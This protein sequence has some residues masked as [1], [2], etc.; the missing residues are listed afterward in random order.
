MSA[1]SKRNRILSRIAI[2]LVITFFVAVLA[3]SLVAARTE[4][5]ISQLLY[6]ESNLPTPP[7]VEVAG[8][9]YVRAAFDHELPSV[10][11]T[12]QDIDVPGWGLMSVKSSAQYVTVTSE[13]VFTGTIEDA[14]ARKVFTRLQLD[15]V[16]IG[17]RME[18]DDLLIQNL[19][20]ISPRGGWETEAVFE[21]TPKGFREP[22]TVEMKLRVV[23]GQVI[24]SPQKIIKAPTS[25]DSTGN[26]VEGEELS[27]STRQEIMDAFRL[28][29]G[30]KSLPLKDK[31]IR[32]YVAGGGVFIESEQFYTSV[33]IQDL[34]PNTRP[35]SEDEEPGL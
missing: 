31:P 27:E 16:S 14:P 22:A 34:M 30:A 1:S 8:F 11:V 33:S 12:A 32:V 24:I 25:A 21:G 4:H 2:G 7:A 19:D 10:T 15:G 9:P 5:R 26:L 20:D 17:H 29:I 18:I 13:D 35:L 23:E 3:D 6:E 28:T